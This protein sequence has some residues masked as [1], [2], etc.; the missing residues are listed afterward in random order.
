MQCCYGGLQVRYCFCV[1]DFLLLK[2]VFEIVD[3]A[4]KL[5]N[6]LTRA[7]NLKINIL[8]III[9]I[10][11]H[12][13]LKLLVSFTQLLIFSLVCDKFVVLFLTIDLIE[14][15]HICIFY[16]LLLQFCFL[17]VKITDHFIKLGS[18]VTHFDG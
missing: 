6:R 12:F 8:N 5:F 10:H 13:I 16:K 15:S 17:M 3:S 4:I 7:L 2:L 18:Q 9:L 1:S 11:T 14:V